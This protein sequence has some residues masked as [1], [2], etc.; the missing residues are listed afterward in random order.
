MQCM[1]P[2]PNARP[3]SM[4]MVLKGLKNVPDEE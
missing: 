3:A 1:M 2:D 4:E